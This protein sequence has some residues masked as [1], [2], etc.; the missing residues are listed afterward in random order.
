MSSGCTLEANALKHTSRRNEC[1]GTWRTESAGEPQR[2]V[3]VP[4]IR[5]C[6]KSRRDSRRKASVDS[7]ESVRGR[8]M[9]I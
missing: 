2:S 8:K 3:R 5:E 9:R 7:V 4:W 6:M 1:T